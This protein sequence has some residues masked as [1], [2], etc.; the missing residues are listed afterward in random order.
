MVKIKILISP[1]RKY[2]YSLVVAFITIF[3]VVSFTSCT[4]SNST[5]YETGE[6]V[7][8]SDSISVPNGMSEQSVD[9]L[10]KEVWQAES[11][12]GWI[13]FSDSTSG[14]IGRATLVF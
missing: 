6:I 14:E 9:V 7:L 13:N 5:K 11:D 1:T 2:F 8:S 4:D 10:S 12:A 3:L